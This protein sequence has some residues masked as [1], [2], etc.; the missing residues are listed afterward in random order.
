MDANLRRAAEFL[1]HDPFRN[2]VLLKTL[3]HY[4]YAIRCHI[5]ERPE[6]AGVLLLLPGGASS[7]DRQN[8]PGT[9][10][11]VFIAATHSDSLL[12]LLQHVPRG[13]KLLFKLVD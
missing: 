5:H 9:D 10:Y 6:A 3:V 8:Y 4:P 11:V 13:K 12:E 1:E 7:F 2:I